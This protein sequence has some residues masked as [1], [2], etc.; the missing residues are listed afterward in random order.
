MKQPGTGFCFRIIFALFVKFIWVFLSFL[1]YFFFFS[2]FFWKVQL[3]TTR[4]RL[5]K[6]KSFLATY[7][8]QKIC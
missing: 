1:S 8:G 3:S 7:L 2:F 5:L 4:S 6:R